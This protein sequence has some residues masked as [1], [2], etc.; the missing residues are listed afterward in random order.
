[1]DAAG[2]G[3]NFTNS[4]AIEKLLNNH[5]L[6]NGSGV[7]AGDYDG[8][9]NVDLFFAGVGGR[10][11]LFRNLGNWKFENATD[12]AGVGCA[13]MAATGAAFVDSDGDGKLDLFVT[14]CGGP[15]AYFKNLGGGKFTN[16]TDAVGFSAKLGS[17]SMTFGD[18]DRDGDIDVYVA[19]YGENTIRS[20]MPFSTRMVAGRE[21]VVGRNAN[22]L[23]ITNGRLIEFGEPDFLGLNDGN[24]KLTPSAF[25]GGLFLDYNG[26]P[27]KAAPWDHGLSAM[28]RDINGDLAP[29]LYVCNDFQT[30][31][32][33]WL[34]DAGK[35]RPLNREALPFTS[36]F[37]MAVD[38]ADFNRDGHV[39]V[40]VADMDQRSRA[41]RLEKIPAEPLPQADGE[42]ESRPQY[43]RNI[44]GLNRGDGT[45]AEIAELAGLAASEW[46]WS[47]AFLDVDL[48][49]YEDLLIG[50]GHPY[51][52]IDQDTTAMTA[53]WKQTRAQTKTNLLA[54]PTLTAPNMLFK[55]N[56]DLTFTEVG[57]S[58]GFSAT[59]VSHGFCLADLDNDG[60]QDVIVNSFQTAPLLYRN[61]STAPRMAVRLA[62]AGKNTRGIGARIE[63]KSPKLNQSQE[64]IAG[65]RYLS[66]DDP[67]RTF[68]WFEG[69]R[70][71]VTWPS[72]RRSVVENAN[73]NHIYEIKETAATDAAVTQRAGK[74]RWFE[75]ASSNLKH[76]PGFGDDFNA[77]PLLSERFSN[78]SPGILVTNKS[79]I[80][81]I[82]SGVFAS[83]DIDK[84]GD[85]DLF[86]AGRCATGK[87]PAAEASVLL[88][89]NNGSFAADQQ[90]AVGLV[91]GAHFADINGDGAPDLLLAR[92]WAP[93]AIYIN[94]G[95][96]LVDA[97]AQFGLE[98]FSGCWN[99]VATGDFNGDGKLDIVASNLG[100]NHRFERFRPTPMRVYYGDFDGS[101]SLEI[102]EAVVENGK[103]G[104][105]A[106]MQKLGKGIPDL[107]HRFKTAERFSAASVEEI[108]GDH[109]AQFLEAS[110]F[111]STLFLNTGDKFEASAL[112]GE[113]QFAPGFGLAVADFDADGALD[114]FLSQNQSG[115]CAEYSP[116]NAGRGALLKGDG[117]GGFASIPANES[118]ISISGDQRGCAVADFNGDGG[119]DLA[120]GVHGGPLKLF[121]NALGKER[122]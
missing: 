69:A 50:N 111:D 75:P 92:A 28:F 11:G 10:S 120:V 52:T 82:S 42:W 23:K 56:R 104:P 26:Q 87:W 62:G 74:Q 100:R 89:N 37:S 31:D 60:D 91:N 113:A 94:R 80:A 67:L 58:W 81:M 88:R 122:K 79:E 6:L 110:W 33:I 18:V 90:F 117:K 49:G 102:I 112:P 66:S 64:M 121:H 101:G 115:L 15:N 61:E 63:V 99:G 83:A 27:L 95:G 65:G 57:A 17:T 5:N 36:W 103:A 98:K 3:V 48:D 8:D 68:A 16:M 55:N 93:L 2:A 41:E 29:D 39:D 43:R 109:T 106:L 40:F 76:D 21:V 84:D 114:I 20:G 96:K 12:S 118:G 44:L 38:F 78:L 108:L 107:S 86:A 24:G 54:F 4:L 7:A 77:Q 51:D 47:A 32:R 22:R 71:E 9:G 30:P 70:I 59:N 105:L 1:M 97:T 85:L 116:M 45:F 25:T 14:S 13:G 46:T 72:G 119:I 53:Q 73:A 35:L 34:N 19:N